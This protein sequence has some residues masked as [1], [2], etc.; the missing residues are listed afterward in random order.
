MRT[1]A[2]ALVALPVRELRNVSV[3][4]RALVAAAIHERSK[5]RAHSYVASRLL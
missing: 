5:F 2:I 4:A 3:V 1:T